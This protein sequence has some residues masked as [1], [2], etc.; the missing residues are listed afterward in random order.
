M[1]HP[2]GAVSK[3]CRIQNLSRSCASLAPRL[4]GVACKCG[5]ALRN[6]GQELAASVPQERQWLSVQ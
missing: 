3:A 4:P 1:L 5:A 6:G 2:A